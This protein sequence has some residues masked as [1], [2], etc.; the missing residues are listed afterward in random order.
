MT[1]Q[2]STIEKILVELSKGILGADQVSGI[3]NDPAEFPTA[4]IDKLCLATALNYWTGQINFQD[5]DYIVNNLFL[6]WMHNES[7]FNHH[8]FP[9]IAWEC[10][11]A[12]DAGEFYREND[13]RYIDPPEKYTRPL[14][15]N[16]LREQNQIV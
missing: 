9:D 15:E 8:K 14:V 11:N 2:D 7:Y 1:E 16:L 10:Y 5:G 6:L 12:F 13:D 3:L 4:L